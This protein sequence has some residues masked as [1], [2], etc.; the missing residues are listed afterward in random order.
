MSRKFGSLPLVLML[1]AALF[2]TYAAANNPAPA[3]SEQ[4]VAAGSTSGLGGIVMSSPSMMVITTAVPVRIPGRVLQPG[5]YDFELTNS[6]NTVQV[7]A[8]GSHQVYGVY[9]VIPASRAHAGD[10]A[11]VTVVAAPNGGPQRIA[12][13]FF[14]GR[15]NGYA[16]LYPKNESKGTVVAMK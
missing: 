16:F 8:A 9:M 4:P 11:Q 14:P 6:D 1:V 7:S 15:T 2:V 13:W 10:A 5:T 3:D 12:A